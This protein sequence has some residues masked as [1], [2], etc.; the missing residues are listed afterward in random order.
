ML[1]ELTVTPRGLCGMQQRKHRLQQ[2]RTDALLMFSLRKLHEQYIQLGFF[3][4]PQRRISLLQA[5]GMPEVAGGRISSDI[6]QALINSVGGGPGWVIFGGPPKFGYLFELQF[7]SN[8]IAMRAH[9]I[10]LIVGGSA[11]VPR[12]YFRDD[13]VF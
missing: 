7:L 13:G 5:P 12:P 2:L 10:H 3:H 6:T 1:R 11:P 9:Q 8:P 4:N